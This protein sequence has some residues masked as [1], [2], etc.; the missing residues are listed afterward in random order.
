MN[1]LWI[2]TSVLYR[3]EASQTSSDNC[4]SLFVESVKTAGK[5]VPGVAFVWEQEV[6]FHRVAS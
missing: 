4:F 3:I 5:S 6:L 1:K 2:P